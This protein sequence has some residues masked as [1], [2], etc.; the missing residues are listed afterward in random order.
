MKSLSFAFYSLVGTFFANVAHAQQAGGDEWIK[1]GTGMID[2]LIAAIQTYST[3]ITI[4]AIIA[5][6]IAAAVSGQANWGR[7]VLILI[8]GICIA[9]SPE[10]VTYL[11]SIT[12]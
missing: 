10:A 5:T 1:A 11:T 2:K 7:T 9:I 8:C 12:K 3:Q 4:L 6:L